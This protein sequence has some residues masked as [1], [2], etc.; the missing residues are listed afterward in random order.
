MFEFA[1]RVVLGRTRHRIDGGHDVFSS[2]GSGDL[3]TGS[4]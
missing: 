1:G 2:E 4:E 3:C